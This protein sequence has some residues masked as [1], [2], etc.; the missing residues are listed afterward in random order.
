MK[1]ELLM[2]GMKDTALIALEKDPGKN[3]IA[4]FYKYPVSPRSATWWERENNLSNHD[5]SLH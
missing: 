3:V 1:K 5:N 2:H 4:S